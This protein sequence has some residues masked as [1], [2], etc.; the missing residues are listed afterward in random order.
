MAVTA[1]AKKILEDALSL[2]SEERMELMAALSDSFE[3]AADDLSPEWKA[4]IQSRIREVER[5]EVT[6]VPW[7]EVQT[8]IRETLARHR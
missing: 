7:S 4:E 8:K 2:S 3:P 5:G 1:A 6:L